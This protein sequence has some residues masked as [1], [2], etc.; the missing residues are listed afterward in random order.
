[1]ALSS[2]TGKE[3][4]VSFPESQLVKLSEVVDLLGGDEMPVGGIFVG[5]AGGL[6]G[7]ILIVLPVEG[8][9]LFHDRMHG[10]PAGTSSSIDEVDMSAI[11]EFGNILSASFINAI[12]NGTKLSVKSAS[13][14]IIVDMCEAVIDSVLARFNQPGERILITEAVIYSDEDEQAACHLLMFLEPESLK[15]LTATLVD[16]LDGPSQQG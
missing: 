6:E 7:G 10:R 12:S 2:L 1:M 3:V 9:L 15:V 5:V 14:E 13:P 16:D 11:S 8:V 4:R